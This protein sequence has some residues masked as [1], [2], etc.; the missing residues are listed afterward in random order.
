MARDMAHVHKL[1][2]FDLEK[3]F[4]KPKNKK[5]P[6]CGSFMAYHKQPVPRWHC[7]KCGYT[8]YVR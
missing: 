4:I 1:Y 3:G 7:G 8:E 5:C 6:K 2:E